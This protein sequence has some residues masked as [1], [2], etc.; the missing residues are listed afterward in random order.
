MK[1]V[2]LAAGEGSRMRPLTYTRPKVMLPIANKP[3][4]EHLLVEARAA[5]IKDFVFIV[6]YRD[7]SVRDYFGS[8]RKW[9]VNVKYHNQRKQ[10]G[11]ADA[12]RMIEHLVDGKFLVMNGDIIVRREDIKK[13]MRRTG[14]TM[15]VFEVQ[16]TGDLGAVV[17]QGRRVVRIME[18]VKGEVVPSKLANAGLYLFYP[19][20]FDAISHTGK[21]PRGEYE[22]TES[23][24]WL[25]ERGNG[26]GH[27]K[28]GYWLDLSYPWNLLDVNE[29]LLPETKANNLA[30]VENN[31]FIKG[32]VSINS[33]TIIKSGTYIEG[34][35]VI[36]SDCRIGPNCYI[37]PNS[38]IGDRCHIGN[39]VE[40]KNSIIMN[41]SKV[42]HLSYVGDSVIG[43]NCNLGAG[44]KI[45]NLRFD[46]QEIIVGGKATKRRK[47][48]AII[49][50]NVETGIN[51]SINSG[52]TI[53]NNTWI[54][55]S[56]NVTGVI[57][58]DSRIF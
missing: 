1:A 14:T 28:I 50:D 41:N 15:S 22:I 46:K 18:K 4:V 10:S 53:G 3:I 30:T 43:E 27:L 7:E 31:V 25:V 19:D 17:V 51:V 35:V 8:G 6:G 49:G 37:R 9:D 24:Q 57:A 58:P 42:P 56:A 47:L 52:T 36:G 45:A 23:L 38:A 55:P 26:V 44:T 21:S 2:I 29:N 16:N 12:L 5:G 48:G 32:N 40:I 11:T 33:G 20:I 13:L 54:G 34:P 39:G